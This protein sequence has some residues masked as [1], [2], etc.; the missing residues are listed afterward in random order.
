[1]CVGPHIYLTVNICVCQLV[2]KMSK[3]MHVC[4]WRKF[5]KVYGAIILA[6]HIHF[7]LLE[8]NNVEFHQTF[9]C[10]IEMLM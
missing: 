7:I 1:M 2:R 4:M 3:K 9:I 5:Y 6:A 10:R 8:E